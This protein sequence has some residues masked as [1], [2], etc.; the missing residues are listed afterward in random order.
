M[1]RVDLLTLLAGSFLLGSCDDI[2]AKDIT[3]DLPVVIMPVANSTIEENPVHFKWNELEGATKY[4]LEVVSPSFANIQEFALDSVVT[5]T[6]FFFALDSNTYQ[7]RLTAL[8]AGYESQTTAPITFTVG[9]DVAVPSDVVVLNIPAVDAYEN[10]DFDGKFKWYPLDGVDHYT[11]ELHKGSTFN[12]P[13]TDAIPD[14]ES[15]V[16][17]SYDG[18]E[19]EEGKYVWGVK[20]FM[21]DGSE[22]AFS[23]RFLTIDRTAPALAT[24]VSP[25]SND[26]VYLSVEGSTVTFTWTEPTEDDE[27]AAVKAV[28]EIAETSNFSSIV[29]TDETDFNGLLS[30]NVDFSDGD[31]G[32]GTYYWRVRLIDE[33]GNIGANPASGYLLNVLP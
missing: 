2:I 33:A 15:N 7:F 30:M 18:E 14:T 8:N 24:M 10:G 26:E 19:L 25:F 29:Y 12:D 1:K 3:E 22:T 9:A 32:P 23:K 21:E 31:L 5:G 28:L 17:T 20:A 13:T 11:F 27:A 6:N 4:H 16:I